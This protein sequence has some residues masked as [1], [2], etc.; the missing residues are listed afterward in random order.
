MGTAEGE[1]TDRVSPLAAPCMLPYQPANQPWKMN[2]GGETV[3]GDNHR[4]LHAWYCK[5]GQNSW[6]DKP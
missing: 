5:R 2:H 6:L 3:H 4:L 1:E